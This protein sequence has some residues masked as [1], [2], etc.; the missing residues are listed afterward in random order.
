MKHEDIVRIFE[1][2]EII[3]PFQLDQIVKKS[4]KM[5]CMIKESLEKKTGLHLSKSL[6]FGNKRRLMTVLVEPSTR[7]QKSF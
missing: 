7:A 2:K 6:T 4:Y 3:P 1:S 5:T